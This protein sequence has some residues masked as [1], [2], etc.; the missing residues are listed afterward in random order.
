[1]KKLPKPVNWNQ[2]EVADEYVGYG[3]SSVNQKQN[4]PIFSFG[5]ESS[6]VNVPSLKT[7]TSD[8]TRWSLRSNTSSIIDKRDEF[9]L[10]ILSS[11]KG[12]TRGIKPSCGAEGSD[13]CRQNLERWSHSMDRS[14]SGSFLDFSWHAV[15]RG[16]TL[17]QHT[18]MCLVRSFLTWA[19]IYMN[20]AADRA[21]LLRERRCKLVCRYI[22]LN[23]V[24]ALSNS[25]DI[26]SHDSENSRPT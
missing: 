16:S 9:C 18:Q 2:K 24:I 19:C 25:K 11:S 8:V 3:F 7:W 4:L 26:I 21:H 10:D 5:S 17:L 15:T 23:L 22:D 20:Q 14:L 12:I 13:K 6:G 1:M